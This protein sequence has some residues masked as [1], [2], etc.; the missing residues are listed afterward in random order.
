MNKHRLPFDIEFLLESILD[1][2]P[3]TI[4]LSGNSN[5]KTKESDAA[6]LNSLGADVPKTGGTF[7]WRA[8][9]AYAFFFDVESGVV[10]YAKKT[11][12]TDMEDMLR[13][14]AHK[15]TGFP[16]TFK[17]MYKVFRDEFGNLAAYSYQEKEQDEHFATVSFVGLKQQGDDVETVRNYLHNNRLR[18]FRPLDIRGGVGDTATVP[19]GRIWIN[20]NAV[21]FWNSKDAIVNENFTLVEKMMSAMKLDSKKFAYEFLDTRGMFAYKELRA[22]DNREKLSPEEMKKL[23]AVQHL[24]SKAKKKLAGPTYK[25]AHLKKAAKG[26]DY[27]ARADAAVPALEGHIKLKNLL[28]ENPDFVSTLEAGKIAQYYDA[29][30]VA[31]FAYPKFSALNRGGVHYDMLHTMRNIY[32][33]LSDYV[34]HPDEAESLMI[35]DGYEISSAK[36]MLD[37]LQHGALGDYF[38]NY[39][40]HHRSSGSGSDKTEDVGAFRTQSGGLAGRIWNKKKIISFW[41]RKEDVIKRWNDIEKMFADFQS[42][43]GNLSD[44][45]VDWLERDVSRHL[46]LTPADQVAATTGTE[47]DQTSFLDKLFGDTKISDEDIKKLQARL[48]TM[49]AKEKKKV[50]ISMGYKNTKASDIA[51]KLGMTVA[52]FNHIMNVNEGDQI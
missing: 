36:G 10:M 49:S 45:R 33:D 3:D 8:D 18:F 29:D 1:E 31:F 5:D 44:Y 52:E 21:S 43:L 32:K 12:H 20:K 19:A 50:M 47:K 48:H 30:A 4:E 24:D 40:S 37:T 25:A 34:Q 13:G 2:S 35:D 23:M 14:A 42:K 51:D 39:E 7:K 9:D 22:A 46:P 27:A 17:N 15:A 38:K 11:T 6:R 16:T 41:N 26:F 28:K